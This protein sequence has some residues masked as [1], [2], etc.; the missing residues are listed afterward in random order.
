MP[1]SKLSF[2]K[3]K[4]RKLEGHDY[5]IEEGEDEEYTS[6]KEKKKHKRHKSHKLKH[7]H[8][9]Y[10]PPTISDDL[11]G[12]WVPPSTSVKKD[13]SEWNERLFDAMIDD[14]GQ[15]FH[16]SQ[17]NSYWQPTPDNGPSGR[18]NINQMTDEEYRQYIVS[19]IYERTHADEIRAEKE[20]QEKRKKAK[21][22]KEKAQARTRD[23]EAKRERERE[24]TR[25]IR[26][27]Q[28]LGV[29]RK[30]YQEQ[31]ETFDSGSTS[32]KKLGLKDIPWPFAGSEVSKS[33]VKDFLLYDIQ[34]MAEQKKV[35]R[36]EQ[37][38]YH[39]DKFMQK[40]SSRLVDNEEERNSVAERINHI[41]SCLND[42]WSEL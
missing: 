31:W 41:S 34:D 18:S 23:E 5:D 22:A 3:Q 21:A 39:P 15:D 9:T 19:G 16:S 32:R 38:R 10:K 2:K 37:I 24:A 40:I 33:A 7:S 30:Q 6:K 17:F 27:L 1:L 25:K 20:R 26:Q 14:E 42:I 12:G 35:I 13:D 36:K 28:K 29:S 11:E 4:K 8:F